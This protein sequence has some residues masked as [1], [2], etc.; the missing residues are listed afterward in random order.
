MKYTGFNLDGK[1][2]LVT[3]ASRGIG[4]AIAIGMAQAGADVAIAARSED[5]LSRVAREIEAAGRRALV[6]PVDISDLEQVRAI[7]EKVKDYFGKIDILMS[8][9][10]ML[11]HAAAL[12]TTEEDWDK[13]MNVNLKAPYFL[14]QA[15]GKIMVNQQTGGS[16]ICTTSEVSDV[17]ETNFGA[18]CPSKGG[19]KMVAKVLATEWG[20]YG[21]RVNCLAPCFIQNK[22]GDPEALF[23]TDGKNSKF[24]EEK[25]KRVP[26]GR[27][28]APDDMVG[29][30]IFLA[31]DAAS[32]VS[33]TTIL[34]DGGYTAH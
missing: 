18:Y 13:V 17:A 16:I 27:V 8:N 32:Y 22:E 23:K 7:P 26:A 29:A 28:G 3:G 5:A 2:A 14:M 21:I 10:G 33:G 11:I 1:V 30:A 25:L 6:I 12:E 15:V 34:C 24:V 31:S 9:A 20:K 4:K 19:L